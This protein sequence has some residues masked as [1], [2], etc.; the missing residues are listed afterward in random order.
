M[1]SVQEA[2]SAVSACTAVAPIT[3]DAAACS[4]AG[5]V[6]L[7]HNLV[8][9][10]RTQGIR[11]RKRTRPAVFVAK[12]VRVG[13]WALNSTVVGDAVV[14]FYFARRQILLCW[15]VQG[16]GRRVVIPLSEITRIDV[17]HCSGLKS[18]L[19]I[20]Y[21]AGRML[22]QQELDPLPGVP[23]A[24]IACENR[25]A[26]ELLQAR[27][28]AVV[29]CQSMELS[30]PLSK[31]LFLHPHLQKVFHGS[32]V[33]NADHSRQARSSTHGE[34]LCDSV[35]AQGTRESLQLISSSETAVSLA[36]F[37]TIDAVSA[38]REILPV[39]P[40]FSQLTSPSDNELYARPAALQFSSSNVS[41]ISGAQPDVDDSIAS[42]FGAGPDDSMYNTLLKMLPVFG[43]TSS[44]SASALAGIGCCFLSG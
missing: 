10:Y 2:F 29:T 32:L 22:L 21:R 17:T 18:Q 35:T 14:R 25:K 43:N 28:R 12:S 9:E 40:K 6:P 23:T 37:N 39:L 41:S 15:L 5:L 36:E 4:A 19:T 8:T 13:E 7:P 30:R 16:V 1:T 33:S 44:H 20:E 11:Q 34:A 27:G 26:L 3:G 24:W 42:S 38:I 31:L